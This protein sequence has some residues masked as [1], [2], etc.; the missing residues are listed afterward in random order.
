MS[1]I[2]VICH[3]KLKTTI[4]IKLTCTEIQTKQ[5]FAW[6]HLPKSHTRRD[7]WASIKT[8]KKS[9]KQKH[10]LSHRWHCHVCEIFTMWM[11]VRVR[12]RA[13]ARVR[14]IFDWRMRLPEVDLLSDQA[15]EWHTAL[16]DLKSKSE[17]TRRHHLGCQQ[18]DHLET[19]QRK[20]VRD[21]AGHPKANTITQ[22]ENERQTWITLNNK[23]SCVSSSSWWSGL[24]TGDGFACSSS[25]ARFNTLVECVMDSLYIMIKAAPA[26]TPR[27]AVWASKHF[28]IIQIVRRRKAIHTVSNRRGEIVAMVVW[29]HLARRVRSCKEEYMKI[30]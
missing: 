26:A 7:W 16:M 9:I 5:T 18:L 30:V 27:V 29:R 25:L 3:K 24:T 15:H 11:G 10:N 4:R 19:P 1:R 8:A 23:A 28:R 12:V 13:C 14:W 2:R 21:H 20:C 22:S 17:R 6:T